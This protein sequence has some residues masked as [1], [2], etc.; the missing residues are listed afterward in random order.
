[1][2]RKIAA[3]LMVSMA[4]ALYG[5]GTGSSAGGA[6]EGKAPQQTDAG[7]AEVNVEPRIELQ[8]EPA[9]KEQAPEAEPK[10]EPAVAETSP[11]A[12][13]ETGTDTGSDKPEDA[14]GDTSLS[15][16]TE[17][18]YYGNRIFIPDGFVDATTYYEGYEKN[19]AAGGMSLTFYNE[20]MNM[21]IDVS[22]YPYPLVYDMDSTPEQILQGEADFY[23][24][25]YGETDVHDG[26][27]DCVWDDQPDHKNRLRYIVDDICHAVTVT[28][29]AEKDGEYSKVADK[30][31]E[32]FEIVSH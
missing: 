25:S 20:Q 2:K 3:A 23:R 24:S 32:S 9:E 11:E 18:T 4:L 13:Q 26:Y 29:P 28:Y 16:R 22:E 6:A 21:T 5:C 17:E 27:F 1:M 7:S 14:S 30:V 31:I 8:S 12:E 15:G 10:N 19:N